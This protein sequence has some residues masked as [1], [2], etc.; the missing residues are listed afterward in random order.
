MISL[1]KSFPQVAMSKM[2]RMKGAV[3]GNFGRQKIKSRPGTYNISKRTLYKSN[4][5]IPRPDDAIALYIEAY[6]E[7]ED[8]KLQ[9]SLMEM[10]R[11]HYNKRIDN[12]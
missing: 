2:P 3:T 11:N 1:Y 9:Q 12:V 4:M 7:T 8:P 10:I 5:N 6:N